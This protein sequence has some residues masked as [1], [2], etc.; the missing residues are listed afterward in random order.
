SFYET[1]QEPRRVPRGIA[2]RVLARYEKYYV[3]RYENGDTEAIATAKERL[4]FAVIRV[5]E[6]DKEEQTMAV[7]PRF[8]E[9]ARTRDA[10]TGTTSQV[11]DQVTAYRAFINDGEDWVLLNVETLEPL[12]VGYGSF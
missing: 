6:R 10:K 12:L 8:A 5:K 2:E 7:Y 1:G 4:P 11:G 3:N 9:G